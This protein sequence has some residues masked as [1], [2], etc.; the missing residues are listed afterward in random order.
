MGV[1]AEVPE[2]AALVGEHGIDGRVV[3]QQ[4]APLR[5]ASVVLVQRI[6]QGRG[7]GRA[8]A[9]RDEGDALVQRAA[10][11]R[12]GFFGIALA[13]QAQQGQ[14]ARA[15]G[16]PHAALF[17]DALHRPQQVAEHRLTGIGEGAR[18]SFDE[19]DAHGLDAW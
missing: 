14:W 8:V 16:Q 9:L 15:T 12:Q 4:G 19:C 11:Q 2:A 10:Q 13:V 1:E 6:D 17:V 5:V 18:K 3:Q 7:R